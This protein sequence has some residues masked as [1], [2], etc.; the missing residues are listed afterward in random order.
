MNADSNEYNAEGKARFPE[1]G[2]HNPLAAGDNSD[3]AGA[4]R[5]LREVLRDQ[6]QAAILAAAE[7]VLLQEG[8]DARIQ[9]IAA[10]AGVAVGTIYNHFGDRE[11]VVAAVLAQGRADLLSKLDAA[12]EGATPD[13][14]G[15][16]NRF[17]RVFSDHW[18]RHGALLTL[19]VQQ[20]DLPK[21]TQCDRRSMTQAIRQRVRAMVARGVATGHLRGDIGDD[22]AD[23]LHAMIW[24]VMARNLIDGESRDPMPGAI[25]LFLRG[26][27]AA[28]TST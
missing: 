11:G 17:G 21:L 15:D 10:R 23:L 24:G 6:T 12:L 8:L 4:P 3:G 18:R 19:V 27:A 7:Q 14:L 16:F 2:V 1:D 28:P 25:D 13:W 26:A 20:P 9:T 5:R 22:Q